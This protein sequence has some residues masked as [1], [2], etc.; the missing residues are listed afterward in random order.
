M[1][2]V[3]ANTQTTGTSSQYQL[4]ITIL[5]VWLLLYISYYERDVMEIQTVLMME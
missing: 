4:A 5:Q 3:Y 2:R 1:K